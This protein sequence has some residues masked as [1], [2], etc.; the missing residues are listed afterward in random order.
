MVEDR[1]VPEAH[2]ER[3]CLHE[4]CEMLGRVDSAKLFDRGG[5]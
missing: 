5:S 1:V 4:T 3:G 2:V